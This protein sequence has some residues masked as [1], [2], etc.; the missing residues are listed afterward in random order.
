MLP[1][2]RTYQPGSA[3]RRGAGIGSDWIRLFDDAFNR[4]L[5]GWTAW[6]P[7]ADLYETEDEFVLEMGLPGFD[8][9]SIDVTVERGVLTVTGRREA[10]DETASREYHV[11][12]HTFDRFTRSFSLPSSVVVD[13]VSAEYEGGMLSV[14]LPKAAEAKPMRVQIAAKK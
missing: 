12:E 13:D 6:T 9:E 4:D 3:I 7:L 1:Q 5:N 2:L 10:T 14:R 11:R 8:A